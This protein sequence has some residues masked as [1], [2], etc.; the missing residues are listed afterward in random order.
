MPYV[1]I[2]RCATGELYVGM[3][4]DLEGRLVRHND[5][6]A[7]RFTAIRRPVQLVYSEPQDSSR[8][9]V[10][11]ERQLK[12]WTRATKEALIG[13]DFRALHVMSTRRKP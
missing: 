8:T 10:A 6:T 9:A 3:P 13:G 4:G 5:G 2:L 11:R 1:Y 7:C 12:R